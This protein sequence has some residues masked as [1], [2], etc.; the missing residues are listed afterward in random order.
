MAYELF[1][2]TLQIL[3]TYVSVNNNLCGKLVLSLESPVTFDER[4]RVT[5]VVFF[6]PDFNL[7]AYEL[8]NAT[9]KLLH[10]VILY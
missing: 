10:W 4:F 6:I 7:L 8:G 3:R 9:F 2:K 1:A 5:S